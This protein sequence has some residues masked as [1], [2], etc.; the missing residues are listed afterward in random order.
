ML[1]RYGTNADFIGSF[2]GHVLSEQWGLE[3][4]GAQTQGIVLKMLLLL[5]FASPSV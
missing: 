5:P 4:V 3:G 2:D 1:T